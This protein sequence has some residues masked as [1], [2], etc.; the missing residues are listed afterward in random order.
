MTAEHISG[1]SESSDPQKPS[2]DRAST[3]A[4][5]ISSDRSWSTPL[6]I[7][8]V[9]SSQV[10]ALVSMSPHIHSA[11]GS[12]YPGHMTLATF[13]QKSGSPATQSSGCSS[14]GQTS[15]SPATQSS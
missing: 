15:G 7:P 6:M 5:T 3:M 10:I 1:S 11:L 9:H 12:Q 2:P 8:D 14:R 4:A 13:T